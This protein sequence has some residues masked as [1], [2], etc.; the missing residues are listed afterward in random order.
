MLHLTNKQELATTMRKFYVISNKNKD[1][2]QV[3]CKRYSMFPSGPFTGENVRFFISNPIETAKYNNHIYNLKMYSRITD[4]AMFAHFFPA[5]FKLWF[6]RTYN[7][8]V[9]GKKCLYGAK[10]LCKRNK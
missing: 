10:N 3:R 2:E 1:P 7:L 9:S 5:G 6:Y 8:T 4:N